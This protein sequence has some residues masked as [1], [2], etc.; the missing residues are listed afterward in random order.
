M[1]FQE[2]AS[3]N[4]TGSVLGDNQPTAYNDFKEITVKPRYNEDRQETGKMCSL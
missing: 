2:A 4:I 1:S 3:V